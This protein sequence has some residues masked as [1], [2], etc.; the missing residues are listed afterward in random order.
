M[1]KLAILGSPLPYG[2]AWQLSMDCLTILRIQADRNC[3]SAHENAFSP[4]GSITEVELLISMR[5]LNQRQYATAEEKNSI[6][7]G[8]PPQNS[9]TRA[10]RILLLGYRSSSGSAQSRPLPTADR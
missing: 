9:T 3:E 1:N 8:R 2:L 6:W 7:A 5:R 4:D 10:T